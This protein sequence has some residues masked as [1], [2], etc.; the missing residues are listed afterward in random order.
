MQPLWRIL[1]RSYKKL[2]VELPYNPPT[3]LLGIYP[4]AIKMLI[5][6]GLRTPKFMEALLTIAKLWKD[7]KCPS[8]EVRW[9]GGLGNWV[10][11]IQ[12]AFV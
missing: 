8:T 3:V 10:K 12:R 4:K 2:K 7:P 9:M 11:G 6:R 5:S 1:W